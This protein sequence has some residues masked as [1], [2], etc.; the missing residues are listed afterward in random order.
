M[1]T[2]VEKATR[3]AILSLVTVLIGGLEKEIGGSVLEHQEGDRG[4]RKNGYVGHI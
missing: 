2:G 3:M 1:N 4:E